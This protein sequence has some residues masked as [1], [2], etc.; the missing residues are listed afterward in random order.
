MVIMRRLFLTA[1]SGLFF[2]VLIGCH[3]EPIVFEAVTI[4]GFGLT[5]VT[6][7]EMIASGFDEQGQI[8][9]DEFI[10]NDYLL[11]LL[12]ELEIEFEIPEIPATTFVL[13]LLDVEF[14]HDQNEELSFEFVEQTVTTSEMATFTE[15]I[16]TDA[17]VFTFA[18][19]QKSDESVTE[20]EWSTDESL[21][22]V[23]VT[24]IENIEDEVL[25]ATV[26]MEAVY[27]TNQLV[28][29]FSDVVQTEITARWE[30]QEY[31]AYAEEQARLEAER[32]A[33][34]QN[35]QAIPAIQLEEEVTQFRPDVPMLTQIEDEIN[36][37]VAGRNNIGVIYLCL[38]TGQRIAVNGNRNFFSAS[39]MKLPTHMSVAEA[40]QAGTLSWDQVLTV[41]QGDIAGGSGVL[42]N[43]IGVG[44]ELTLR[45]SM[46]YSIVYSDNIGHRMVTRAIL[47]DFTPYTG[48]ELTNAVFNRYLAGQAPVGRMMM[49]PNQVTDIFQVLYQNRYSVDGYGIILNYMRN[50]SWR[51]RFNT[52]PASSYVAH[53]PGWQDRAEWLNYYS[54]DSG[55][56]F[57]ANPYVLVVM[58]SGVSNATN[59][60]SEISNAVFYINRHF[61]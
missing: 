53:T 5:V 47:P 60:I 13:T 26:A 1:L 20:W 17:G 41:S 24:V 31:L 58:T 10:T 19:T 49:T 11:E 9:E 29:D 45:N 2:L 38:E 57:T 35:V 7:I 39:I 15:I 14:Y 46:R 40:V 37:L 21:F 52:N 44:H 55:I 30:Q 43:R 4:D 61:H 16:F 12:T 36:R 51:N 8:I 50:T 54:H 23:V 33:Q 25:V 32:L 56:F 18:I 6:E 34:I 28:L 27:F 42:Q 3:N 22:T 48:M 59:L